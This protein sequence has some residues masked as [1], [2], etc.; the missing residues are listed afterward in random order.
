V[1]ESRVVGVTIGRKEAQSSIPEKESSTASPEKKV[2]KKS[3]WENPQAFLDIV[4]RLDTRGIP[5]RV[6]PGMVDRIPCMLKVYAVHVSGSITKFTVM[7]SMG[8]NMVLARAVK[9]V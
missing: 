2:S 3:R 8:L 6:T 5:T 4:A 7:A 1:D 9:F